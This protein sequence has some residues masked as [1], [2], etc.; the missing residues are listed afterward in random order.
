MLATTPRPTL[1]EQANS[2]PRTGR[3]ITS[4]FCETQKRGRQA[5]PQDRTSTTGR[6]CEKSHIAV[7]SGHKPYWEYSKSVRY[8]FQEG[9][10]QEGTKGQDPAIK[11]QLPSSS[12]LPKT[13]HSP[14]ESRHSV[15]WTFS[16]S[17]QHCSGRDGRKVLAAKPHPSKASSSPGTL[18]RKDTTLQHCTE[19]S[20]SRSSLLGFPSLK[21]LVFDTI[22]ISLAGSTCGHGCIGQQASLQGGHLPLGG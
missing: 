21:P 16:D 12:P 14:T 13:H 1:S 17:A 5:R 9:R 19:A 7:V 10:T 3:R 4:S 20:F 11:R 22:L 6:R 2:T 18:S 15:R 8:S